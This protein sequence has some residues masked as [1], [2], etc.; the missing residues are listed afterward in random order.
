MPGWNEV[1]AEIAQVSAVGPVDLVRRKYLSLLSQYTRR[2]TIAYYSGWLTNQQN[3]PV[4]TINDE[5]K[6]AFMATIHKMDRSLGLD[7]ILHTPGGSLAAVE[8]IVNYLRQMFGDNI[9]AIVPQIAMSAGTMMACA[10]KE[11]LMGKESNLGPIDPQLNGLSA[12]GV[13]EEFEKAIKGVTEN[14]SSIPIWQTIIGKYHPSFLRECEDTIYW[15]EKIVKDWLKTG[16]FKNDSKRVSKANR[17]VGELSWGKENLNHGRH[18]HIDFCE[19]IGLIINKIEKDPKLQDLVLTV[20]HAF[21]HTFALSTALKIV[22]NDKGIAMVRLRQS[23]P[24]QQQISSQF[25]A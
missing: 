16:M 15:A 14:P 12:F 4:F 5:D 25:S 8:S 24:P 17:I 22:E 10:S 7:L 23:L 9:R 13:L 18:L 3:L 21:M 2:N 20:H 6:N 11:I 19:K 1:L